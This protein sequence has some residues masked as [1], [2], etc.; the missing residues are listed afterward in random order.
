MLNHSTKEITFRQCEAIIQ[1]GLDVMYKVDR[2][3][4]L[5]HDMGLYEGKYQNFEA[6][7]QDK[8]NIIERHNYVFLNGAPNKLHLPLPQNNTTRRI[9]ESRK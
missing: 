9:Y 4:S 5:I 8:W 1:E 6:Y 2:A 7:C 3:L